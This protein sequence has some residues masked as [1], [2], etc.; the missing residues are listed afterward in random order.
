MN[1]KAI[2]AIV[3]FSTAASLLLVCIGIFITHSMNTPTQGLTHGFVIEMLSE[4][5]FQS[6][7]AKA[8]GWLFSASLISSL[9]T[10]VYLNKCKST[11]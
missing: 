7:H 2:V 8:F 5:R 9:A 1:I 11:T 10:T 6:F 4:P 3:G